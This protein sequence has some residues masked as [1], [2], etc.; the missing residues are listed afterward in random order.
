MS[1]M[2]VSDTDLSSRPPQTL[3]VD[4]EDGC[5]MAGWIQGHVMVTIEPLQN[6]WNC[7]HHTEFYFHKYPQSWF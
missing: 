7:Q 6:L 5:G 1:D 2:G 4:T 3:A